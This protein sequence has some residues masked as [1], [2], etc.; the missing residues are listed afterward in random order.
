MTDLL[1]AD[2]II[3]LIRVNKDRSC[4]LEHT[5]GCFVYIDRIEVA[6]AA[7]DV[8]RVEDLCEDLTTCT[9]MSLE[10]QYCRSLAY[11]Y[12]GAVYQSLVRF[13][14]AEDYY[15]QSLRGFRM[16]QCRDE[17]RREWYEVL[18]RFS[19]GLL[20][21]AQGDLSQAQD[22]YDSCLKRIAQLAGV[23]GQTQP[24]MNEQKCS[25]LHNLEK[26]ILDR[27]RRL[28][29][30]RAQRE[31][32]VQRKEGIPIIGTTA[33]GEPILALQI[34]PGAFPNSVLVS[35]QH[36][37]VIGLASKKTGLQVGYQPGG[38]DFALGIRGESMLGVGIMDG[39][40]VIFRP[41][42]SADQGDIVVVRIDYSDG[43]RSTV[44][45]FSRQS[46]T[47]HLKAENPLHRPQ[48]LTFGRHDPTVAIIG[49]A[50]AVAKVVI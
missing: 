18:A 28:S 36:C 16:A 26:H 46:D 14:V 31:E 9:T 50:V 19:L 29:T 42:P 7:S 30:I 6:R 3:D 12:L 22:L 13:D 23:N 11:L 44:K 32:A 25:E 47:I 17:N 4:C 8:R 40:F 41:Q 21:Q 34:E 2:Q 38:K 49:R 5:D 27:L 20:S 43:A 45:T 33:A 15:R 37:K 1:P 10:A 48:V 24:E 35:G 39:D